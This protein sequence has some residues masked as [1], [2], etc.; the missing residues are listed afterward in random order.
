M[1]RSLPIALSVCLLSI[2]VPGSAAETKGSAS[3]VARLLVPR[4]AW[5]QGVQQ[6]AQDAQ[7]KLQSHPGSKLQYPPDF[8]G[9]V[10]SEVE[11]VLPY[12][13]LVG[14]HAKELGARYSEQEL[15]ELLAFYRTPTGQKF[16][17]VMPAATESVSRQTQ[18]RFEQKMPEVM[19]KLAQLAKADSNASSGS[20]SAK[21]K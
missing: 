10:R 11:A 21:K 7:S 20:G 18:Q 13:E 15:K 17:K 16:L 6:L 14:M 9:K 5:A 2:A 4:E 8:A 19:K 3:E 12:D 1:N